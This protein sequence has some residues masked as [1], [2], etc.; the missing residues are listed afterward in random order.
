[1]NWLSDFLKP[2]VHLN[3]QLQECAYELAS[4]KEHTEDAIRILNADYINFDRPPLSNPNNLDEE[5][6]INEV[7]QR[8]LRF[9]SFR[10][11]SF[12]SNCN[13]IS[14]DQVEYTYADN[15]K[16]ILNYTKLEAFEYKV[17]VLDAARFLKTELAYLIPGKENFFKNFIVFDFGRMEGLTSLRQHSLQE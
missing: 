13:F 9:G 7:M 5:V 4:V 14:K 8:H 2:I 10:L 16:V 6:S 17:L 11:S 15:K 3:K 12:L 1:M